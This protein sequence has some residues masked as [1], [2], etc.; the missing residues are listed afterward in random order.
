MRVAVVNVSLQLAYLRDIHK[1]ALIDFVGV[2][3][4]ARPDNVDSPHLGSTDNIIEII[5]KYNINALIIS[6]ID[7]LRN[8]INNLVE[9]KLHGTE[10]FDLPSFYE[11]VYGKI[12]VDYLKNEWI[13]FRPFDGFKENIL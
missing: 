4:D 2:I 6:D 3:C 12:P 10:I 5:K 1:L 9:L 8:Q 13:L 11:N 7:P